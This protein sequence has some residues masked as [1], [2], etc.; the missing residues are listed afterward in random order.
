MD[1][2]ATRRAGFQLLSRR[3]IRCRG[4]ARM[5]CKRVL[6]SWAFVAGALVSSLPVTGQTADQQPSQNVKEEHDTQVDQA[7][8]HNPVLWHDPGHIVELDLMNGQGG[9]DSKPAPP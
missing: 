1:A 3:N 6:L 7:K 5:I 4:S 8:L 9:N 2:P